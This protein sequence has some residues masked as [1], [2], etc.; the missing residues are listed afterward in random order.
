MRV[1][2]S[3]FTLIES[4]VAFAIM[5]V[6]LVAVYQAFGNGLRNERISGQRHADLLEARSLVERL[7]HEIALAEGS[8][9]GTFGS[10]SDWELTLTQLEF[11]E[12]DSNAAD[13]GSI[14]A[15]YV[16]LDVSTR[17]GRGFQLR[18]VRPGRQ[19]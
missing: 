8:V 1:R 4:L 6:T 14:Q 16:L 11:P 5:A 7:G 10:G 13:P 12:I 15:I 19:P 9:S 17:D 3:G 18:T 2:D